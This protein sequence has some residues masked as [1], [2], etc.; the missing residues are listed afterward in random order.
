MKTPPLLFLL[1]F[2]TASRA[3]TLVPDSSS[4][5]IQPMQSIDK[6]IDSVRIC[7]TAPA[8]VT[9]DSIIIKFLNG[10]SA[11]FSRGKN[12][13]PQNYFEYFYQGWV[14]GMTNKTLRYIR[15]SV[16]LLQDSLG[17]PVA[18]SNNAFSKLSNSPICS[19]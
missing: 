3:I 13:N 19:A 6:V 18:N 5:T 10:D 15:D 11:D 14:Y 2:F 8:S 7:S 17:T 1:F 4:V 9:I 12:C 16:F